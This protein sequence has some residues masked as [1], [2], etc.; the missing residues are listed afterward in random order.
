HGAMVYVDA[1]GATVG[2][3]DVFTKIAMCRK[4]YAACGLGEGFVDQFVR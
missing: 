2:Y 4:H 1:A 3:E